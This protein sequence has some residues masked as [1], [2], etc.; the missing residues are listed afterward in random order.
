MTIFHARC[1]TVGITERLKEDSKITKIHILE[2][3]TANVFSSWFFYKNLHI[4]RIMLSEYGC[5]VLF[6]LPTKIS[7][8]H[9][10]CISSSDGGADTFNSRIVSCWRRRKTGRE[11]EGEEEKRMWDCTR[12][13][14]WAG[15][16]AKC[17]THLALFTDL[18][19]CYH[20]PSFT[21]EDTTAQRDKGEVAAV[22]ELVTGPSEA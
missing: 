2:I 8:D 9:L 18:C 16:C 17:F 7:F 11:K 3:S 10:Y 13:W 19:Y 4:Y 6:F 5:K 1:H 20:Q 12:W 21:D 14:H 22:S 15:Y